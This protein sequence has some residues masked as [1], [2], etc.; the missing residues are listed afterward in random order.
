MTFLE[1][2]A[3]VEG[4]ASSF[5]GGPSVL[6]LGVV[7]VPYADVSYER[8]KSKK[9]RTGGAKRPQQDAA[10][11]KPNTKTTGDVAEILEEK[12]HIMEAFFDAL[13]ADMI[14]KSLEQSVEDAIADIQN[15]APA[16]G[17][18]ITLQAEQEME[19]AFRIFIDQQEMDGTGTSGLPIPTRAAR[20]G[21]N[22]RLLHPYAKG[23]P[24]RPSFRDTG[25]YE[26][27]FKA[28]ID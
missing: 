17:L 5:P 22:H 18:Q 19:T 9:F 26:A 14:A 12:Y 23:N 20:H 3:P 15:G 6:H 2:I 25:L 4:G 1:Q 7:D 13:G 11:S 21:V 28:W 8:S 24:A 16:K 10:G 27:S